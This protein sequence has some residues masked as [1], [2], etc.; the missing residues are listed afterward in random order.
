M[1]SSR[2]GTAGPVRVE[3]ISPSAT[4]PLPPFGPPRA[5]LLLFRR[6]NGPYSHKRIAVLNS[7]GQPIVAAVA[8]AATATVALAY[9]VKGD[10]DHADALS[11]TQRRPA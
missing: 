11:K 5:G 7:E 10:I 1:K 4:N 3:C 8:A 9:A 6:P 2:R